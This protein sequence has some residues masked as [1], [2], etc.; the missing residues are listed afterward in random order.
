MPPG[1]LSR[2][3]ARKHE[4]C[5]LVQQHI[6][7]TE[8]AVAAKRRQTCP[9]RLRADTDERQSNSVIKMIVCAPTT[10]EFQFLGER[11][12]R[13]AS[14]GNVACWSASRQ[15]GAETSVVGL[16]RIQRVLCKTR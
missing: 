2:A 1:R 12:L 10:Y 9:R 11:T 15:E 5:G 14:S 8:C 6:E 4:R 13:T 7:E 3:S 16:R